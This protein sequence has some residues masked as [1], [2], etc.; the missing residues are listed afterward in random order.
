MIDIEKYVKF[1]EKQIEKYKK[2]T[3]IDID[4]IYR[5]GL[6]EGLQMAYDAIDYFDEIEELNERKLNT[7]LG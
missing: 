5:K 2:Q 6:L 4:P 7:P 3:I 1:L